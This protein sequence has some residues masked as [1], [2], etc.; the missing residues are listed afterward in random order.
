[1]LEFSQ[2][3]DIQSESFVLGGTLKVRENEG[4]HL[5]SPS[6]AICAPRGTRD[7]E[8]FQE[9]DRASRDIGFQI[10][11]SQGSC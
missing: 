10:P 5:G 9:R 8:V 3:D 1:M 7:S 2:E 4:K 6:I 11:L